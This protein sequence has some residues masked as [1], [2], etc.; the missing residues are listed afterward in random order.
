VAFFMVLAVLG[1]IF[2]LV[3]GKKVSTD[4]IALQSERSQPR[5]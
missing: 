3:G 2:A 5:L 1:G 4:A